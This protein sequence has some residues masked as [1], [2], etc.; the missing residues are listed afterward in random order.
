MEVNILSKFAD[1]AKV[2]RIV[3]NLEDAE[4][5]Q[6]VLVKLMDWADT[7]Q[8]NFNLG[9]CQMLHFGRNQQD[10]VYTLGGDPQAGPGCERVIGVII[11]CDMK[12]S[13][14]CITAA[15]KA[16]QTLGRMARAFSY[17]DKKVWL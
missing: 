10:T 7:W 14:Q 8:M 9:K 5:M 17:R 4:K 6:S 13:K 11:S 1:D 12:P 2:G 15:K 3:N 16:N